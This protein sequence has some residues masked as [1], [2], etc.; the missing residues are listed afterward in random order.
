MFATKIG[1]Q[2]RLRAQALLDGG[3][4]EPYD[5]SAVFRIEDV[6]TPLEDA[7]ALAAGLRVQDRLVSAALVAA[8]S[9]ATGCPTQAEAAGSITQSITVT[10]RVA[11]WVK[12]NLEH[13]QMQ[14]TVTPDDVARGYVEVS[15][16]SRFT[17]TTN[18]RAGYTLNFQPQADI[19]RSVAIHG[20][21]VSVEIGSGGGTVIQS[22]ADFGIVRTLLELGYRFY[23]AEA[24]Q[25]G[26]Y[27]WPL[28]LSVSAR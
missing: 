28:S 9:I 1:V 22:G 18:N 11:P 12:L 25:A 21:G 15:A 8:V 6:L 17:V 13:Q 14:L 7:T 3:I 19:F 2:N 10:A 26:S 27:S 16:A 5:L 20:L 4:L 23:L 24:V